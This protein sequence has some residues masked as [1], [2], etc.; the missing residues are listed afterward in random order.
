MGAFLSGVAR[1]LLAALPFLR[2]GKAEREA[3]INPASAEDGR[4]D[5]L[6]NGALRRLGALTPNDSLLQKVFSGAAAIAVRPDH[7]S[8]PYVREWLSLSDTRESLKKLAKAHLVSA[9]SP[10]ELQESLIN[11]YMRISGEHRSLA[12]DCVNISVAFLKASVQA[13]ALDAGGAAISQ[14]GFESLHYRFDGVNRGLEGVTEDLRSSHSEQA[15]S[16]R[17]LANVFGEQSKSLEDIEK[18]IS[19]SEKQGILFGE[20]AGADSQIIDAEALGRLEVVIRSRFFN[21]FDS[22][23]SVRQL[24]SN[25]E[26]GDLLRVS[27]LVKAK[28]YG[29]CARLLTT[30]D[31]DLAE[32][33]IEKGASLG[34]VEELGVAR[35]FVKAKRGDVA[36]AIESLANVDSDLSRSAALII[37]NNY[38]GG[39]EA[40][41]WLN[42]A[43]LSI[44][45]LDPDGKV[46]AINICMDIEE[47]GVALDFVDELVDSDIISAPALAY[48]SALVH[49]VQVVPSELISLVS[50]P[51]PFDS[52]GFPLAG[53]PADIDHRNKAIGFYERAAEFASQLGLSKV[54]N[55]SADAALWLALRDSE[56][57]KSAIAELEKS[58]RDNR[59]SLRRLPLAL[60]FGLSVDLTAVEREIERQTTLSAGKSTDAAVARLALAFRQETPD[61]FLEY[62]ENH[63]AQLFDQ[64]NAKAIG[65]YEVE[66]LVRSGQLKGARERIEALTSQGLTDI[67]KIRLVRMIDEAEGTDPVEQRLSI[68]EMSG[69]L[70]DLRNLVDALEQQ[71]NWPKVATYAGILFDNTRDLSDFKRLVNALYSSGE[72]DRSLSLLEEY[73]VFLQQSERLMVLKCWVLYELGLFLAASELLRELRGSGDCDEYRQLAVSIA[74][75]S[76]DWESLQVF[77]EN[78]WAARNERSAEDLLRVAKL[79]E[80]IQSTRLKELVYEVARRGSTDPAILIGCYSIATESGWE[81]DAEVFSW[82]KTAASLSGESGPVQQISLQEL[83]ERQPAW[84]SRESEAWRLHTEGKLPIV[85]VASLLNRSFFSL[86]ILPALA[87]DN[88]PDVRRRNLIYAFSGSRKALHIELSTIAIDATSLL[89]LQMLGLTQR[90]FDAFSE[91]V[92]THGFLRWLFA[93]KQKI[94]FHQPSKVADAN[95][96]RRY[97]ADGSLRV[98][99]PTTI[100]SQDLLLEVGEGLA[101][102]LSEV[103]AS[104]ADSKGQSLVVRSSPVHKVGSLVQEVAELEGY[105]EYLCSCTAIVE[106]LVKKGVLTA[107]KADECR[108]Y[109]SLH[110]QPWPNTSVIDASSSL[111]LD[112][113]SV[114]YFQ[115]LGILQKI[116]RAGFAVYI[117]AR[118]LE[119]ADALIEYDSQASRIKDLVDGLRIS[120]RDGILSGKV[121]VDKLFRADRESADDL[122]ENP[123]F[124]LLKMHRSV[125]QIALDDRFINQHA[126]VEVGAGEVRVVSSIDII[127]A[128]NFKGLISNDELCE[129]LTK[130]RR[131][132]MLFVPLDSSELKS[133]LQGSRVDEGVLLEAAE[134]RAVRESYLR[135]VMSDVVQSPQE[136]IWLNMFFEACA[137][138]LKSLWY[139]G[140][141]E[142]SA[143]VKSDWLLE[144]L[145][146]RKL[147]HVYKEPFES[148]VERYS[149]QVTALMLVPVG[150]PAAVKEMYWRW[151]EDSV[152]QPIKDSDPVFYSKL[153]ARAANIIELGLRD[154]PLLD[155]AG[156]Q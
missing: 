112:D 13:A 123:F 155:E 39:R 105:E 4:V 10:A 135:I 154:D 129:C 102:M 88:V 69:S 100:P 1:G 25:I 7:F 83:L 98:F 153:V 140:C 47:W 148:I 29:W 62:I 84:E 14:A 145:D 80:H 79:A 130:L 65:F 8:K 108:S 52:A 89:T 36:S 132:G 150:L 33:L 121:K 30:V 114:S 118:E 151:Y 120:L 28:I 67:E 53:R 87:N 96:I 63:R 21:G 110:E 117:S 99:E 40:H 143:R 82:L 73:S 41:K 138:A 93:E 106:E 142:V 107:T 97:I 75:T 91:V 51:P 61:K 146:V 58:M 24:L 48:L 68:Y 34:D 90:V 85:A 17:L 16:I 15:E 141:D 116:C 124:D 95:E 37:I 57:K 6:L 111:V 23:K 56:K 103:A 122:R 92:I 115:H 54:A 66:M 64:L 152:L 49:L 149:A 113:V 31:A 74:V 2:R 136:L 94:P 46:I 19:R 109:L 71:R 139:A 125:D 43:G 5:D 137:E 45:D 147:A 20:L 42:G 127:S 77:V 128:L 81:S 55:I 144:L 72:L 86:Y 156:L 27:G 60:Q 26:S 70:G 101:S 11:G 59:H 3:G 35:A 126:Y 38:Q 32:S 78:E 50:Q 18:V 76:G 119:E 22:E 9:P 44:K 12:E 131:F 134:L 104:R 133:Y